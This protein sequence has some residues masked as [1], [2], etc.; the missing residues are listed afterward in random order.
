MV[1]DENQVA[2]HYELATF[3]DGVQFARAEIVAELAD[4]SVTVVVVHEFD[5]VVTVVP[6]AGLSEF[7]LADEDSE[8]DD[9]LDRV[10]ANTVAPPELELE[11][12][13]EG[14]AFTPIGASTRVFLA[15]Q[16]SGIRPNRPDEEPPT[17]LR[18]RCDGP[19]RHVVMRPSGSTGASCNEVVTAGTTCSGRL[20]RY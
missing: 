17:S 1:W 10:I 7:L 14:L 19:V 11:D 13:L 12:A 8:I 5:R 4:P 6:A 9:V 20:A 18:Y 2:V 15:L 3:A 16:P